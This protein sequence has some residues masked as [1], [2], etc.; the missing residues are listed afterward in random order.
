MIIGEEVRLS[1]QDA[2]KET[3]HGAVRIKLRGYS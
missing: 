1:I 2:L 3:G